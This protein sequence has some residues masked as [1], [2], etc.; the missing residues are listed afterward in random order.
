M[1]LLTEKDQERYEANIVAVD[2]P[3][4]P[5]TN[6]AAQML[7]VKIEDLFKKTKLYMQ[8]RDGFWK[9]WTNNKKYSSQGMNYEKAQAQVNVM[10]GLLHDYDLVDA[11]REWEELNYG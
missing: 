11:F 10:F 3:D 7:A 5:S 2:N 4:K 9:E 6:K 8:V 1:T